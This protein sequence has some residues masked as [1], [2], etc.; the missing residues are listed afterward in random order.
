MSTVFRLAVMGDLPELLRLEEQCFSTDRLSRRSFRWMI[1]GA[2]GRLLVARCGEELA[3]YAVVLFH[4]SSSVARLYSLAIA[5]RARGKGLGRGLL[6]RVEACARERKCADLRLEVRVDNPVAIALY[7][8][9]GYRPFGLIP[10]FYQDN[11][12]AL[13]M[14]KTL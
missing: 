2:N 12:D 14:N 8:R 3:G 5:D 13:R 4:R 7:E 11:V 9:N 1:E 10:A 6:E